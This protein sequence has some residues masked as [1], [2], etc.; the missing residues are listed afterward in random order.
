MTGPG[1][2]GDSGDTWNRYSAEPGAKD[3]SKIVNLLDAKGNPTGVSFQLTGATVGRGAGLGPRQLYYSFHSVSQP[4]T[5]TI[6]ITGLSPDHSYDLYLYSSKGLPVN[7]YDHCAEFTFGNVTKEPSA[8]ADAGKHSVE[9]DESAN[10]VIIRAMADENGCLTGTMA[11]A[12]G[13]PNP[14][15]VING[16]QIIKS[17][18]CPEYGMKKIAHDGKSYLDMWRTI[19]S[20]EHSIRHNGSDETF[21]YRG[22]IWKPGQLSLHPGMLGE[23]CLVRWTAP[24]SGEYK[25]SAEFIGVSIPHTTVDLYILNDDVTIYNGFINIKGRGNIANYS[26]AV[27]VNKGDDV[28]FIVGKGDDDPFGDTTVLEL[29]ITS[30]RGTVY[31]V[32]SDFSVSNNPNGVWTFGCLSPGAKP[33]PSAFTIYDKTGEI[34]AGFKPH[35][36]GVWPSEPPASCPFELS[37]EIVGLS[38]TGKYSDYSLGDTWYPSWASDGNMYSPFTD[39]GCPREDGVVDMSGSLGERPTTG[40][41]VMIGDDPLNL[42]IHSLGVT[43]GYAVPYQGRYPCG[44]LVYNGVWYYGTYC[45]GPSGW[46]KN[47]GHTYNWPVLG[48]VPGFRTSTDYGKTWTAPPTTPMSPLFPEPARFMGPVKIGK[49]HFV[50]FGKNMEHSPDGKAYLVANGAKE[51]DPMPRYANLCWGTGDQIYITRVLPSIKNIN[52]ESKYE[53]FAG[54]D[55]K[56]HPI[57]SYDFQDI[58]P[59]FD[60]NNN[61]GCVSMTYNAPLKKYLMCVTDAWP[62][63]DRMNSYILESDA[64][65]GPFKLVTYMKNFGQQAY[66]LNIPSKFISED[67][68]G[69]WLCYSA[70]FAIGFDLDIHEDPPGSRY[71]LVL[72]E[73]KLL[74]PSDG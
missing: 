23:Y 11:R 29:T 14:V 60:W 56:G 48:P 62:T 5:A 37:E 15:A 57:W 18:D 31:D 33:D 68:R 2:V 47:K 25:I 58:E 26:G 65:T 52:D 1:V 38:F 12:E 44:S 41:A 63:T 28:D 67:G 53:Y 66:F 27:K 71:G 10:Y 22:T 70:N 45:L 64:I 24:A 36:A 9:Y 61:T 55:K 30:S 50:D 20:M 21:D 59:L 40:H 51:D 46:S 13:R 54:H 42:K 34:D 3:V 43:L 4:E 74:D 69:V 32:A 16:I 73:V 49:P 35:P 19:T 8:G 17:E 6:T 72:Q 39:G 7:V